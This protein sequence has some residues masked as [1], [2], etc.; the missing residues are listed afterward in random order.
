[1]ADSPP[2][3]DSTA[4]NFPN[5][6][7]SLASLAVPPEADGECARPVEFPEGN[8]VTQSSLTQFIGTVD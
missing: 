8:P 3:A 2:Q 5:L 4:R 1:M 7:D 6:Q